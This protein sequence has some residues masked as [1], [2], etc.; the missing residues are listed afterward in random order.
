MFNSFWAD[1]VY[2]VRQWF[3]IYSLLLNICLVFPKPLKILYFPQY[4]LGFFV[5]NWVYFLTL[6]FSS[7][8]FCFYVNNILFRL[9][10]LC[11]IVWNL[12]AWYFWLVFSWDCFGYSG[13][14]VVPYKFYFCVISVKKK[15]PIGIL[16]GLHWICRLLWTMGIL[17]EN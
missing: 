11:N 5:I 16:I 17:C 13:S 14:F 6:S 8:C 3:W 12:R 2:G 1:F 15:R 9:L 7:I 10:H 4:I